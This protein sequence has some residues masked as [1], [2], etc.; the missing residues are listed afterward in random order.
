MYKYSII[1]F[2]AFATINLSAQKVK[3]QESSESIENVTRQGMFVLLELDKK[4]VEKAWVKYLKTYGKTSTST[5]AILVQAA[6]MKA[7]CDYPCRVSS[8]VEVSAL[9][10]KVWWAIDLGPKYVTKE[11]E[12]EYRGAEKMLYEF[13]VNAYKDDVNRQIADAEGALEVATKIHEKEVKEG[14]DLLEKIDNNKIQKTE[15]ETKLQTNKEDYAR[16]NREIDNV[17]L[18]QKTALLNVENIKAS[19]HA[20]VGQIQTDEE[21]KALTEAIKIQQK[22]VNEGERLAKELAKNKQNW[23]DLDAKTKKNASDLIEYLRL[24]EQNKIDQAAAAV[25][26]DKMKKAVEI[27]KDKMNK[28]E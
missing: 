13:A 18:E 25:D 9:G 8:K 16:F 4:E 7:I 2:L 3:V 17:F 23:I 14:T 22:K 24:Q 28:T 11:S 20:A 19:Q 15:L 27:V 6:E 12:A 10:S 1:F 5:G 26:V 21:K